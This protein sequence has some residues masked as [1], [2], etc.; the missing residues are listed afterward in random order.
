MTS[1]LR[2][3]ASKSAIASSIA[4]LVPEPMEKCAVALASPTSTTLSIT[5]VA[6]RMVGKLR[7]SDR[8]AISR[9]P[10]SSSAKMPSIG[11]QHLGFVHAAEAEVLPRVGAGLDDPGRG[12]LFVL[13]AMGENDAVRRFA[14]EILERIHGTGRAQPGEL[15][16]AQVHGGLEMVAVR[17]AHPRVDAVGRDDQVA[18]REILHAA[19]FM[20]ELELHAQAPGPVL[21]QLEQCHARAAAESVPRAADRLALVDHVDVAPIGEGA[22]DRLVGGHVVVAKRAQGLVGEHH[23][24]TE[25]VVGAVALEDRDVP[26]RPVLFRE[27]R[28][29]QATR[30]AADDRDFHCSVPRL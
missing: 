12:A 2:L 24:E 1:T 3:K 9:W 10:A 23:A 28:K 27:Q 20:L 26:G 6:L 25:G 19:G 14:K 30:A 29:V 18:V 16:R 7:H 15:V 8:L 5:Q 11:L 17:L 4:S 13:V 22:P 21:Q